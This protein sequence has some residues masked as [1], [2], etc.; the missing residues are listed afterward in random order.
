MDPW[1]PFLAHAGL[2]H[3]G[4]ADLGRPSVWKVIANRSVSRNTACTETCASRVPGPLGAGTVCQSRNKEG[5]MSDRR[6]EK[7][8]AL[9]ASGA[10]VTYVSSGQFSRMANAE[11]PVAQQ[12]SKKFAARRAATR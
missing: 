11:T 7:K 10:D 1:R 12:L 5:V 4:D 9:G 2:S 3:P 6:F 8:A